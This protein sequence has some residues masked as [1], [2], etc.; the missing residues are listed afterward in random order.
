MPLACSVCQIW[1]LHA[2]NTAADFSTFRGATRRRA[3]STTPPFSSVTNLGRLNAK[4]LNMNDHI[5]SSN[6]I[7]SIDEHEEEVDIESVS[8]AEALLACRAYLQ[9][10]NKLGEWYE[11]EARKELRTQATQ[12]GL[13]GMTAFVVKDSGLDDVRQSAASAQSEEDSAVATGSGSSKRNPVKS[14]AFDGFQTTWNGGPSGTRLRRSEAAKQKWSNP[15]FRQKWYE[16]RWGG[17]RLLKI[18]QQQRANQVKRMEDKVRALKPESFLANPLVSAMT[19]EEIA[20]AIRIYVTSRRRISAT[21][22]KRAA[23][24][25][26]GSQEL[27]LTNEDQVPSR[28]SLM[29]S[30]PDMQ[31]QKRQER[32]AQAKLRYQTRLLNQEE[33]ASSSNEN[34]SVAAKHESNKL[35]LKNLQR[36]T[37]STPRDAMARIN[38]DLDADCSFVTTTPVERVGAFVLYK[39]KEGAA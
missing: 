34:A 5:D 7:N 12:H 14:F 36:P 38:A 4:S 26:E 37:G 27:P 24:R 29:A 28:R 18:K 6:S 11:W 16:Q 23:Q 22:K 17:D 31:A 15:A 19:E 3:A 21:R 9:R 30:S 32:A 1:G 25:K 8:E 33:K 10:K 2:F 20:E 13:Y 35:M 39:L